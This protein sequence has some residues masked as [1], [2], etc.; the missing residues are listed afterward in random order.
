MFTAIL[1]ILASNWKQPE[2][3]LVDEWLNKLLHPN[4]NSNQ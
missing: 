3:P 2:Y 1:F 4:W